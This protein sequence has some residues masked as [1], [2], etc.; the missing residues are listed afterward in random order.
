MK[1]IKID[2]FTEI[3]RARERVCVCMCVLHT[4]KYFIKKCGHFRYSTQDVKLDFPFLEEHFG[5][6]DKKEGKGDKK[7]ES[8]RDKKH[9]TELKNFLEDK[10]AQA[11]NIAIGSKGI[12]NII[13]KYRD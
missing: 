7:D 6:P 1:E 11:L 4:S 13:L 8:K 10:K 9:K 3:D 5:L 2:R 12:N